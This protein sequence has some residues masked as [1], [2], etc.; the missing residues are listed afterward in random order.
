MVVASF[1]VPCIYIY[2]LPADSENKDKEMSVLY[3]VIAPMWNLLIYTLRNVEMKITMRKV[4]FK[5][6]HSELKWVR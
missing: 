6:V 1:F 4:W 5:V 2:V 3:T